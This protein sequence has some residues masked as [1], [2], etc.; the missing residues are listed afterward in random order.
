VEHVPSHG[1]QQLVR[2]RFVRGR[3]RENDRSNDRRR[4]GQPAVA[5]VLRIARNADADGLDEASQRASFPAPS[6]TG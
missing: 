5:R 2:Q 1:A 3:T 6:P 4:R